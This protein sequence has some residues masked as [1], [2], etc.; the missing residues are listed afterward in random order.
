MGI[1][2]QRNVFKITAHK[3]T[4]TKVEVKIE[5]GRAMSSQTTVTYGPDM[6]TPGFRPVVPTKNGKSQ[7]T[8][9]TFEDTS[10]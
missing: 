10:V 6:A 1:L 4:Q 3:E 2:E 8:I 7:T 5:P 9:K